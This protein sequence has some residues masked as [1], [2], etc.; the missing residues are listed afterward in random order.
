MI[1][2]SL[3]SGETE[4]PERMIFAVGAD[5]PALEVQVAS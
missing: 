2:I 4:L 3:P 5:K 1:S